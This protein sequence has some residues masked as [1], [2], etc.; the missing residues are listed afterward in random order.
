MNSISVIFVSAFFILYIISR[1]V[2]EAE[3][4]KLSDAEKIHL[5]D[6]FTVLRKYSL[7]P[8]VLFL[9][10]FFAIFRFFPEIYGSIFIGY[11][12]VLFTFIVG[13]GVYTQIKIKKLE[14]SDT[15]KKKYL[16]VQLLQLFG[17]ICLFISFVIH[18]TS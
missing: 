18:F 10:G 14:I 4:K 17:F 16:I 13:M 1:F 5:I 3:L 7:V 8:I 6:S 2:N 9:V 12:L 11:L 15:Y